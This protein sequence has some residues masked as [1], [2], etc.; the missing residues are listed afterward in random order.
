[1]DKLYIEIADTP[2]KREYGLMDRKTLASNHGMLF[3]FPQ[4]N[5]LSFWMRNTYIPLDIAFINE[6]GKISQIEKMYPL[7]TRSIR[8][9]SDCR[10]ALEVNTG[11]FK[12]NNIK[13]GDK[14]YETALNARKLYSQVV[15]KKPEKK[16]EKKELNIEKSPP[17]ILEDENV[18]DEEVDEG[19]SAPESEVDGNY[20][21][22]V[23]AIP[24]EEGERPEINHIRDLRGKIKFANDNNLEMEVLYWTLRGHM[25]PPRKVKPIDGEG[26]VIKKGKSGEILV[27]FDTSPTIQGGGWSIKGGQPKSFILDNIVQLQI[28]GKNGEQLTDAQINKIRNPQQVQQQAPQNSQEK[29]KGFWDK[30]KN[31]FNK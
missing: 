16:E 21:K 15:K 24:Y 31:I 29:P 8:S 14:I 28:I 19:D 3:K 2:I 7:S 6:D 23:Y 11:W 27:A 9:N 12:N 13:V 17:D 1:M 20:P 30:L 25:L 26:Y 18:I 22:S 5:R 4:S 10:Y